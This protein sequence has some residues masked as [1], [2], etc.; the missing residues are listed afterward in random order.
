MEPSEN[1]QIVVFQNPDFQEHFVFDQSC[2]SEGSQMPT[3]T[4]NKK[5]LEIVTL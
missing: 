2:S 5:Q 1:N 3:T 4:L